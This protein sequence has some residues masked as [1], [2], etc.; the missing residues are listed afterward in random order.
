MKRCFAKLAAG[1]SLAL[2]LLAS[3]IAAQDETTEMDDIVSVM[4]QAFAAPPLTPEEEARLPAASEAVASVMPDGIYARMMKDVMGGMFGALADELDTMPSNEI[5][6]KLNV[7]PEQV[8]EYD[9]A[10]RKEITDLIDPAFSQ[11]GKLSMEAMTASLTNVMAEMEPDVRSGLA[12]AYAQRFTAEQLA[13]INAFFATPTGAVYASESMLVFT[14]PQAMAGSMEA[15][16]KVM[17]AMPT[18]IASMAEATAELPLERGFADLSEGERARLAELT[19]LSMEELALG[20][21]LGAPEDDSQYEDYED[22]EED[23]TAEDAVE[24]VTE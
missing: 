17:D 9:K 6:G 23:M 10:V 22:T 7:L 1:P 19:G 3:P 12:R 8:E 4:Q 24:E 16:P 11:R 20:M 15:L 14:D 21:E 18:M 2:V 13:D 5:A